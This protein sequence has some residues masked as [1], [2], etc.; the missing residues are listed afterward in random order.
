M[1]AGVGLLSMCCISSSIA[2]T[3]M[4]GEEK[5]LPDGNDAAGEAQAAADE[6]QTAADEAQTAADAVAA[7]PNSTPEEVAAAKAKAKAAADKA[8][9]DK[10]AADKAAADKAAADKA[11]ADKAAKDLADAAAAEA[12]RVRIANM[13]FREKVIDGQYPT[14]A[15]CWAA[16][17]PGT[18]SGADKFA[19]CESIGTPYPDYGETGWAY[20]N[21]NT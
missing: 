7:D 8:A 12:E 2:S 6:A 20:C 19:C 10:A 13:S 9:A 21:D 14:F 1:L 16:A 4:G 11:A 18:G 15:G 3:M 5:K 17:G